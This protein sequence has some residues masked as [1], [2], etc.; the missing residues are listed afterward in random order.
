LFSTV[1][2]VA[3]GRRWVSWPHGSR[4]PPAQAA[5]HRPTFADPKTD[6]AFK[7]I[8]GSEQHKDV[9]GAV[10]LVEVEHVVD[11]REVG[12]DPGVEPNTRGRRAARSR[13]RR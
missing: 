1:G 5:M 4:S 9:P 3:V 12:A 8:F 6:F 13:D 7:R 2:C 10:R 11:G